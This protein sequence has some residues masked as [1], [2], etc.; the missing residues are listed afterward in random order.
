[1]RPWKK[2]RWN[3]PI[4]GLTLLVGLSLQA[5]AEQSGRRG[6]VVRSPSEKRDRVKTIEARRR[7]RQ[8]LR[9]NR[10]GSA[11]VNSKG[12]TTLTNRPEKW[13]DRPGYTKIDLG[14]KPISVDT[15]YRRRSS[16]SEFQNAEIAELIRH[17]AALYGLDENLVYAVIKVESDFNRNA[18][19]SKGASGL[20]QLM[21]GTARDMGVHNI[22]NSAENIAGGTQYL[23]RLLRYFNNDVSLALAGYNAGPEN[24]KKYRGIPPF[25]ETQQYVKDVLWY[26]HFYANKGSRP[27]RR[28]PSVLRYPPPGS[29]SP[30]SPK[31][32][33][34]FHSGLCQLVDNVVTEKDYYTVKR[35]QD[36]FKIPKHLVKKIEAPA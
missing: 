9:A 16:G 26:S 7:D 20:M 12:V 5:S 35:D 27:T 18:V 23:A 4:W 8:A 19:S 28:R 32:I 11:F 1:M 22:L 6:V 33:I 13:S 24:V 21:P 30:K 14:L 10:I 31:H 29:R 17:Y 34:Y 2:R 15:R 25:K 3:W 36:T